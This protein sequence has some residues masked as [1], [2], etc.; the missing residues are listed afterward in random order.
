[1]CWKFFNT[2]NDLS[3]KLCVP[4]KIQHLNL[5]MLNMITKANESK[6]LT[7]HL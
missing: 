4:N 5:S 2:L 7:K 3:D 1:M 6:I